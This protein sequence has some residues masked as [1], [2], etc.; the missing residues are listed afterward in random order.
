MRTSKAA[1]RVAFLALMVSAHAGAEEGKPETESASARAD[2]SAGAYL[3]ENVPAFPAQSGIPSE[4]EDF[5]KGLAGLRSKG[6]ET[7]AEGLRVRSMRE[8]GYAYGLRSGVAWRYAQIEEV[9]QKHSAYLDQIY[10][11]QPLLIEGRWLP[12]IVGRFED[13]FA[14]DSETLA[15]AITVGY[16]I[17]AGARIVG[18]APD[19]RGFLMRRF[20]PPEFPADQILPKNRAESDAWAAAVRAGFAKGARQADVIYQANLDVMTNALT[21]MINY[22]ILVS[23]GVM[24]T[25]ATETRQLGIRVG[26]AHVNVGEI[27]YETKAPAGFRQYQEWELTVPDQGKTGGPAGA[28]R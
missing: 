15:S 23:Q 2:E 14:V 20:A 17:D 27:V 10:A 28:Q 9:L 3:L 16:R 11:F 24:T 13:S 18:D 6:L 8:E 19:W 5:V 26:D 21:G 7:G 25:V 4:A 1:R 22:H 12:P